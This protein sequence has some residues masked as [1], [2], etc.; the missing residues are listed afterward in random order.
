MLELL[1]G[2]LKST[3]S[4]FG[5]SEIMIS[6]MCCYVLWRKLDSCDI[7]TPSYISVLTTLRKTCLQRLLPYR[8]GE[9]I[10]AR[11]PQPTPKTLGGKS[12]CAADRAA[13][14]NA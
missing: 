8:Q 3:L 10:P 7:A 14:E 11:S 4:V 9:L 2:A 5:A 6:L 13:G 1:W 12:M